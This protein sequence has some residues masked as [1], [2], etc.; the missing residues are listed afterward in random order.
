MSSR[1]RSLSGHLKCTKECD[2][3]VQQLPSV[4]TV[5]HLMSLLPGQIAGSLSCWLGRG[6]SDTI[7]SD[8]RWSYCLQHQG[9]KNLL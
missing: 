4:K 8:Y 5:G 9:S 6:S 2:L 1:K 3:A 7:H